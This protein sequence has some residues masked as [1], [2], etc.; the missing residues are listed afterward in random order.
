MVEAG[1]EGFEILLVVKPQ[2]RSPQQGEHL[3][4]A[5]FDASVVFFP[6]AHR[7]VGDGGEFALRELVE[8]G[9]VVLEA[10]QVV[11]AVADDYE[12]RFFWV[13]RASPVTRAPSSWAAASLSRGC[14]ATGSSQSSFLPL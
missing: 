1:V 14:W 8:R 13:L 4:S 11:A 7:F 5:G 9:L 12:C 2:D 6:I 10:Q 3:A